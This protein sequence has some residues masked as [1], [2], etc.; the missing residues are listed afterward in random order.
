MTE[1]EGDSENS[2]NVDIL[3]NKQGAELDRQK[4]KS[5]VAI[6]R[7]N[8]LNVSKNVLVKDF[9]VDDNNIP[10][11]KKYNVRK[12]DGN[13]EVDAFALNY[14]RQLATVHIEKVNVIFGPISIGRSGG[15]LDNAVIENEHENTGVKID[16]KSWVYSFSSN[17]VYRWRANENRDGII[18]IEILAQ[19]FDTEYL[20]NNKKAPLELKSRIYFMNKD[21]KDSIY[22]YDT[23]ATI[24]SQYVKMG[25]RL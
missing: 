22:I 9:L 7:E 12:D 4:H 20:E 2:L 24:M 1:E 25:R 23:T 5:F 19:K 8:K 6:A 17:Y 21:N 16:G 13:P 18:G 14:F 10:P 11:L 15:V 3:L